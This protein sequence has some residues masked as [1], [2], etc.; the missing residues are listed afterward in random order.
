MESSHSILTRM[1]KINSE[2]LELTKE[3]EDQQLQLDLIR[4]SSDMKIAIDNFF[5][6]HKTYSKSKYR[7][8]QAKILLDNVNTLLTEIMN[9][10]D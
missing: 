3:V 9:M 10:E 1:V 7:L 5:D 8:K 6:S 2:I 4:V